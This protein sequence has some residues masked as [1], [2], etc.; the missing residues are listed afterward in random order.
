MDL[1]IHDVLKDTGGR[2]DVYTG[3]GVALIPHAMP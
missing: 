3:F 2:T 1:A